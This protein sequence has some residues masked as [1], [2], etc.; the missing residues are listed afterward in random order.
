MMG[1]TTDGSTPLRYS[2]F[3]S[4]AGGNHQ[5]A[6]QNA[7]NVLYGSRGDYR[8]YLDLEGAQIKLTAPVT[9]PTN[10]SF[11]VRTI[12]NGE[13]RADTS[14]TGGTHMLSHMGTTNG[15][16]L[17]VSNLTMDGQGKASWF[18]WDDGNVF[19]LACYFRNPQTGT[20]SPLT[21][22][23][24]GLHC[25]GAASAGLW[26]DFCYLTVSG[27]ASVAP[28]SRTEV[29]IHST[30]G[31]QKIFNTTA[32]Y[33]RHTLI[34]DS[35]GL[36]CSGCHFFQGQ[37]DVSVMRDHTASI[38]VTAGYAG[39]VINNFY[40][41]KSFI[42]ISN[43]ADSSAN[44]IGGLA[45]SGMRAYA[46]SSERNFAFLQGR[47]YHGTSSMKVQDVAVTASLFINRG[48]ATASPS[49]LYNPAQFDRLNFSGI[50][51]RNNSFDG[52]IAPQSNPSTMTQ[53]VSADT[54]H[55]FDYTDRMPMQARPYRVIAL[56]GHRT[57]GTA[58]ALE[59]GN[60]NRTAN[61]VRVDTTT[62][63][64]W[65]GYLTVTVT[66]NVEDPTSHIDG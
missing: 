56:T 30:S 7:I 66:G 3:L 9:F 38:K 59:V 21:L 61:G 39:N 31:D 53:A 45:I 37:T 8:R 4:A 63:N 27:N 29:G 18:K 48:S 49:S 12:T 52:R 34:Y 47:E 32:A 15:P 10:S 43:Q 40:L 41:G 58:Q 26:M 11:A 60:V 51:F 62:P 54:H 2:A 33:L 6:F 17:R 46:D 44:R 36:L 20:L 28:S 35:S 14:F 55:S 22:G 50:M 23:A 1:G 16:Q 5:T 19:F 24:P 42:E 25:V 57:S 65:G 13:I 64:P